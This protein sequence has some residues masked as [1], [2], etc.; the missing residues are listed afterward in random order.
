MLDKSD[1]LQSTTVYLY[2]T[3]ADMKTLMKT[4]TDFLDKKDKSIVNIFDKRYAKLQ[5]DI[6]TLK[7]KLQSID[8]DTHSVDEII[9]NIKRY[10][11]SFYDVVSIEETI[12]LTPK[13]GL[14]KKLSTAMRKAELFAKRIQNQDVFSMILT[15]GNLEKSFKLTHNKKYLNKFKRSYNALVY[16]IDNNIKNSKDIK[17]DLAAYKKY[18]IAMVK[19][20]ETKG[21]DSSKGLLGKMN[22]MLSLNQKLINTMHKT[23][24]PVL[25]SKISS[26]QTIS[27]IVQFLFGVLIVVFL[28]IVISSIVNP[29]KKMI[30]A[31][32]GLTEGD[33]DLTIR[34]QTDTNDEIAEANHYINNFIEE[35]QQVLK[36]VINASVQNLNISESLEKT[37]LNVKERSQTQNKELD[38]TVHEGLI[39]RNDLTEAITEAET[40][41][42]NLLR[43]NANLIETKED[44]LVLVDKVQN[45]SQV[46]IELAESL[47]QLSSDAAQVKDV[48]TVIA[49]IAD[50]T[51]LLALNAAIEA[52]RAGE[53]GRGFAVVADEVRKLAERTQH[54]LSEI[55]ATINVIVQSIVDNANQMNLNSKDIELLASISMNVGEKINETVDIMSQSTQMSEN[56][57]DGY[58]ENAQKTETI[59]QK[60]Q[61][62]GEIATQNAQ[63]IDEV[64]QS[65]VQIHKATE[66]L[67]HNLEV[68]KV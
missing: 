25:E 29:I 1:Q 23:L 42:E 40:G 33:G 6:A 20:T 63:S 2:K 41:K 68:F 62:V 60:I 19:A 66:D 13:N 8:I 34:L 44:I 36:V 53:H 58:R 14:N 3:D 46:Q 28:L 47:S 30:M 9:K 45:S 55:N 17:T 35:V 31:T 65:S 4:S 26:L 7:Q 43:S 52:A 37:A 15:L 56:I 38:E 64:T 24:S 32:K 48:L 50:Q 27:F 54:S 22:S 61:K 16:Y 11:Q 57:L 18:F 10:K 39:M 12:G 51:N 59:I 21:L 49:D 67:N 5:K